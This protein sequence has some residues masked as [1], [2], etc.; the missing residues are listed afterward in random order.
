[1][2]PFK[3]LKQ[4]H[5]TVSELFESIEAAS[6]ETKIARFKKL[7][8]ELDVHAHIE[9]AIFYPALKNK[10]ESRDI[11]LEGYEEHKVIKELLAE[12]NTARKP[13]DEWNAKFTFLQESVEHHVKE[14]EGELF[15]KAKDVL[16]DEQADALGDKMAAEKEK[17]G[18]TVS[19]EVKKPG[20]IKTVVNALFGAG[21]TPAPTRPKSA[22]TTSAKATRTTA[23]ARKKTAK[24]RKAT[25]T[26][27]RAATKA[28]ARKPAAKKPAA[29]AKAA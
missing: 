1:M 2:D 5:K 16:T 13:S 29:K 21:E 17:Q 27:T 11:T 28:T 7:K 14:E 3:L 12:L 9:E 8:S 18:K 26:K 15:S 24:P 25:K 6:G 4:D 23:K 20:L 22:K 19:P 10:E